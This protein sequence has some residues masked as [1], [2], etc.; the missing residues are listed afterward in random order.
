[1]KKKAMFLGIIILAFVFIGLKCSCM[2]P[3]SES[4]SDS[5]STS[6]SESNSESNLAV[7]M[8]NA[9]ANSSNT[10]TSEM[11]GNQISFENNEAP[12]I[13]VEPEYTFA[14]LLWDV[15]SDRFA[16]IIIVIFISEALVLLNVL[17]FGLLTGNLGLT[18]KFSLKNK[19]PDIDNVSIEGDCLIKKV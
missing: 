19:K 9:S 3:S 1:M 6:A 18:T 8:G 10:L 13:P 17:L 2:S 11:T 16:K 12:I 4:I 14:Q 15:Y 7:D 5:T